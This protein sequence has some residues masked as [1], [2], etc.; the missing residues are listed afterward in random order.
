MEGTGQASLFQVPAGVRDRGGGNAYL[1]LSHLLPLTTSDWLPYERPSCREVTI[2]R[3]AFG[4][5]RAAGLVAR[6]TSAALILTAPAP[7]WAY[8]RDYGPFEPG[9][10]PPQVRLTELPVM[11]R[12]IPPANQPGLQYTFGEARS[13]GPR[14]HVRQQDDGCWLALIG[15]NGDTILPPRRVSAYK[16]CASAAYRGDLNQDGKPDYVLH[17]P[18]GGCGLGAE[19]YDRVLLL[20]TATHY[21]VLTEPTVAPGPEDFVRMPPGKGCQIVH[22]T[23]M[24]GEAGQ[25]EKSHNY[26]VYHLLQIDG[27]KITLATLDRRFPKWVLYT[28]KPN[29]KDTQQL[30]EE[31]KKRLLRGVPGGGKL[32]DC[33]IRRAETTGTQ[34]ARSKPKEAASSKVPKTQP[35]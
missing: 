32:I 1:G 24:Y 10:Q 11:D 30:T 35:G 4:R 7:L 29:H 33:F 3:G 5:F 17:F 22:T 25:D 23:F 16:W 2:R 21:A 18:S 12:V 9:K 31:Q 34:P 15:A 19:Y 6:V 28:S 8:P 14:I 13:Q 20:S 27:D 26:W